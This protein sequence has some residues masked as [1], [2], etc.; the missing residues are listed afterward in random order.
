M[1]KGNGTG[2][3]AVWDEA[4]QTFHGG[5]DWKFCDNFVE[6]FSV[7]TNGLG[8]PAKALAAARSV[9]IHHYPPADFEPHLT[10]LANWI[11]GPKADVDARKNVHSRILLGNGAS[12]LIDLVIRLAPRGH[13]KPCKTTAQYK[14]YQRAA[15]ADGRKVID[16]HDKT[17]KAAVLTIINPNNPTGEYMNVQEIKAYIEAEAADDSA[18]LIDESMQ[19]WLGPHWREDS[20]TSQTAWIADLYAKRKISVFVMHSWT[21]IWSCTGIRLGSVLAPTKEHIDRIKT[22]Q[23]PWSVNCMGLAFLTEV[24]KDEEYMKRTWDVTAAWRKE[25][26]DKITQHHPDWKVHGH[27]FLSWLWLDCGSEETA[28]EAVK[29]AKAAG[30]PVRSGKPGYKCNSFVRIAAR[31]AEQHDVLIRA[32]EPL[33][34]SKRQK[35]QH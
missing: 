7:T 17:Q 20:L 14:E 28:E 4:T 23:V 29:L 9:E 32:W 31:P 3:H 21:K 16:P 18:V 33:R 12:E 35:T 22:H 2:S 34:S 10:D 19:L 11:A 27:T 25:T 8:T 6:D 13:F 1:T 15:E 5:Q 30:V 24:L 26:A